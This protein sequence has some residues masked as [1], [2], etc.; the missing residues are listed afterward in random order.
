ME[1]SSKTQKPTIE[2]PEPQLDIKDIDKLLR[3]LYAKLQ[4]FAS[5]DVITIKGNYKV[6]ELDRSKTDIIEIAKALGDKIQVLA[7]THMQL[8]GDV[9]NAIATD[10]V[11]EMSNKDINE[12]HNKTL[13]T[14]LKSRVERFEMLVKFITDLRIRR[15]ESSD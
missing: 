7:Q 9:L 5:L 14:A 1:N 3:K 13:E 10:N 2:E 15:K 11:G 8:D 4:D 12:F 6:F